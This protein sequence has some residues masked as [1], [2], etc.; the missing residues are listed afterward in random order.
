M[1]KK[2]YRYLKDIYSDSEITETIKKPSIIHYAGHPGKPWRMKH[3]YEDYKNYIN[4]L[5]KALRKF[6]FR[7]LRKRFFNKV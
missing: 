6:T 1:N 3:P 5:P 4:S 7:D 2:E